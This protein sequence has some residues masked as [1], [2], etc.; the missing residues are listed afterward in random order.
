MI[1]FIAAYEYSFSEFS[2]L[3]DGTS[4]TH[5]NE[6]HA[7]DVYGQENCKIAVVKQQIPCRRELDLHETANADSRNVSGSEIFINSR[8]I[9]FM[10]ISCFAVPADDSGIIK[11]FS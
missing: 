10:I 4:G 6:H 1:I 2:L 11:R 7:N 3:P 8:S 5:F 9:K